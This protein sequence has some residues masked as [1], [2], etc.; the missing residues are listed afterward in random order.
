MLEALTP[1]SSTSCWDGEYFF[2]YAR[3]EDD[4]EKVKDMWFRAN[5]NG[6]T[7]GF[8]EKDWKSIRALFRRAWAVQEVR[9]AWDGLALEYGEL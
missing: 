6:I 3:Q 7:F 5:D 4:K 1:E 9:V 8:T 2:G